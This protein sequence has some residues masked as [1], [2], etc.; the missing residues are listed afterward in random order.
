MQPNDA[1]FA[2]N[3]DLLTFDP[4][5]SVVIQIHYLALR[6]AIPQIPGTNMRNAFFGN[7][8]HGVKSL[9]L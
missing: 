7:V 8:A 1:T 5:L 4:L 6:K 2:K 3:S 9:L